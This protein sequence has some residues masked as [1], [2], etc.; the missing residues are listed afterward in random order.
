LIDFISQAYLRDA[1]VIWF[2]SIRE[3]NLC[4]LLHGLKIIGEAPARFETSFTQ[5]RKAKEQ[6][7]QI[8]AS[9]LFLAIIA[10]R[11]IALGFKLCSFHLSMLSGGMS[12]LQGEP[13]CGGWRR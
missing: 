2:V 4:W 1:D 5:K 12:P 10:L 6:H 7:G 9:K 11:L 8:T 13:S 3:Q